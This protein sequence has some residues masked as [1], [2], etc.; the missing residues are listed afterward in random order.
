M[1]HK[2]TIAGVEL[3][4]EAGSK[5]RFPSF[6]EKIAEAHYHVIY[7]GVCVGE[8]YLNQGTWRAFT[9]CVSSDTDGTL[10]GCIRSLIR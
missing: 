9:I 8:V 1:A 3:S 2:T 5:C 7:K 10:D 4:T 6:L